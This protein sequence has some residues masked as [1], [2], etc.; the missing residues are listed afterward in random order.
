MLVLVRTPIGARLTLLALVA[1]AA[2]LLSE[3]DDRGAGV[4]DG[5]RKVREIRASSAPLIA[6]D[7]AG[8]QERMRREG[9]CYARDTDALINDWLTQF[10][11]RERRRMRDWSEYHGVQASATKAGFTI[12]TASAPDADGWY[13]LEVKRKAGR[14]T[15]T[16]G[17][18]PAPGCRKGRWRIQAHGLVASYLLGR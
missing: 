13:R 3:L 9:R 5:N 11:R 8:Y 1:V 14:I 15:A 2:I 17:G 10:P 16:C 12:D 7:L 18:S 6:S 4:G